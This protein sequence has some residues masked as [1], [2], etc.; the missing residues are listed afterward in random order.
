[1]GWWR[2]PSVVVVEGFSKMTVMDCKNIQ[3]KTTTN[4][5]IWIIRLQIENIVRLCR[6]YG[7][8]LST[9]LL[10][11]RAEWILMR[12][13]E[14]FALMLI[15]SKISQWR[16]FGAFFSQKGGFNQMLLTLYLNV[17][18]STCFVFSTVPFSTYIFHNQHG[19]LILQFDVNKFG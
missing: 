4:I 1:M 3:Y 10:K 5:G 7:N 14:S 2:L 19:D 13:D 9:W 11:M 15:T 16:Y 6:S 17:V 12:P 18:L 8:S